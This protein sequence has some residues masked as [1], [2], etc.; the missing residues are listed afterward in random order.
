MGEELNVMLAGKERGLL[1]VKNRVGI[2][3]F[4]ECALNQNG[5]SMSIL[6]PVDPIRV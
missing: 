1:P 4:P 6:L 5:K 3:M 2:V